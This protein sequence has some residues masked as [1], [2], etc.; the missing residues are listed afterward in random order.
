MTCTHQL[1]GGPLVCIETSPHHTHV[2]HSTSGIPD[3]P[4]EE[5]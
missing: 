1:F 5:F 4:K 2:Y 3:C